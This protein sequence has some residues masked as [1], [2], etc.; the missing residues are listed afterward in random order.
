MRGV[1]GLEHRRKNRL[2]L[3]LRGERA[4][5]LTTMVSVPAAAIA[6]A[7]IFSAPASPPVTSTS[8]TRT[9]D[10]ET[11]MTKPAP[12]PMRPVAATPEL[13]EAAPLLIAPRSPAV[14]TAPVLARE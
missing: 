4:F 1:S 11:S 3:W 13:L 12:A 8:R 2:E 14:F 7:E 9:E 6:A 5:G 10:D